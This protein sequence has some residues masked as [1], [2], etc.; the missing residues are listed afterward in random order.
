[1]KSRRTIEE[2]I[3]NKL[4]VAAGLALHDRVLAHVRQAD[5]Q[6]KESTPARSRPSIRRTIM[7]S[8][9]TKWAIGAA[10][11]VAVGTGL[12]SLWHDGGPAAYAFAQTVEAMQ[13]KRS[14][15]IQT[16]FQQRRK[17]EFW[18]EFDK[19]GSLIRF[20]QEEEGTAQGPL[21]TIWEN[22]IVHRYYPAPLNL[23][24]YARLPNTEHR[25]EGLEEFDPETIVREIQTLMEDGKAVMETDK[26]ARY[27]KLMTLRVTRKD[28]PLKQVLL[29]NP[30]TKSVIRV[31]D[32]WGVGEG[33]GVHKG[34]EVLEYNEAMDPKLFVPDFPKDAIL[35]DQVTQEVGLAQGD[36]TGNEAAVAV[37][38]QALEAWAEGDYA[39]AGKLFGGVPPQWFTKHGDLRPVRIISVGEAEE[40]GKLP[41]Y[42][43]PCQYEIQRDGQKST[44]TVGLAVLRVE[45]QPGHWYPT[46]LSYEPE[47][48]AERLDLGTTKVGLAQGRWSDEEAAVQLTR[49]FFESLIAGDHDAAGRLVPVGR[50][51][52]LKRNLAAVKILRIVSIGSATPVPGSENKVLAVPCTIEFEEKGQKD[53][54]AL[55][56]I[57]ARHGDRWLLENLDE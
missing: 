21:I 33:E 18:A 19:Q 23:H 22:G 38:R 54:K 14:F 47:A 49:R 51:A 56:A 16:Y 40:T 50:A 53:S 37:A 20:R 34:I 36:K 15:H 45:G 35:M 5:A 12:I 30:A 28:K 31:D 4:R 1:M 25:L 39:Q 24:L 3:R 48:N 41:P 44:L 57:I 52:A 8:P 2:A 43:I 17:D 27:A 7:K 6:F 42:W 46:V 26:L 11:V 10:A 13:G 29:V 55:K 9:N 32:Y